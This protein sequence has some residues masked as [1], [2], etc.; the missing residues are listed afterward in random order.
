LFRWSVLYP[1]RDGDTVGAPPRTVQCIGESLP[2]G[3][4]IYGDDVND[5]DP[6]QRVDVEQDELDEFI[7]EL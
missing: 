5:D 4:S 3:Y 6:T 1:D 2:R 7:L